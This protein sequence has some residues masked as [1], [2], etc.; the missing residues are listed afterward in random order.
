MDFT[1]DHYY[2]VSLERMSQAH[3]LYRAGAG[4]YSLAMYTA[5]LAVECLLRAYI[6]KRKRQFESRLDLLLLVRESGMLDLQW[7]RLQAKGIT[8][9]QL[10][11]HRKTL[12]LALNE[13]INL[14]QNNYRFASESRLLKHLK[15][16]KLF[17]GARGNLLKA[18]TNTLL[19]A[20]QKFLDKGVFQW[21]WH[22][23]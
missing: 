11:I 22:T 13:V 6:V 19:N 9:Q 23:N 7:D 20:A 10:E 4:N 14:W 17:R 15:K 3:S 21:E 2:Q 5:G 18:K 12:W 16:Q 1:A 8:S